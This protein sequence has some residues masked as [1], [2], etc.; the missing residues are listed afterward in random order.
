MFCRQAVH[1]LH[2]ASDRPG[3]YGPAKVIDLACGAGVVLPHGQPAD[4]ASS[5][6]LPHPLATAH[7]PGSS[8]SEPPDAVSRVHQTP[9]IPAVRRG[10]E[11]LY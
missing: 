3:A 6:T 2:Y 4:D 10:S 1:E 7:R 9:Q 8:A 11:V 5:I